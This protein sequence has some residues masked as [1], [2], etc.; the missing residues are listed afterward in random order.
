MKSIRKV[1]LNDIAR[2]LDMT[3]ATVSRALNGHTAI[4]EQT[5]K[6][7]QKTAKRLNYTP[8]N[9]AS[10]LRLG[11]SRIIG[12]IIPSAEINFFGSVV[13]G[14]EKIAN[15]HGYTVLLYQSNELLDFEQKG[16]QTFIRSRVDGVLA[17]LSKEA[18]NADHFREIRKRGIPLVLFD[19]VDDSLG[20]PS[21]V[22]NDYLGA[23]NA[24]QHLIDQGCKRIA[25]IG[26]QQH[27]QIFASRF[28]GYMDALKKNNRKIDEKLIMHGE[29]TIDSGR[30]CM[31]EVLTRAKPDGV[32]A[33]EDFTALG[34]MQALKNAGK[35]IP[36]D[37]A[38]IG[39][40]NETFGQYI[41]PSL[42]TI[43]QQTIRMGE[44]AA[45][46]FFNTSASGNFYEK[47][48]TKLVLEPVS[49]YRK[50]SLRAAV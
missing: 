1:T 10:S 48:P 19:R 42:S 34:C 7:V 30:D 14:I 27:V 20:V 47:P 46:M 40:A 37:V 15:E 36:D 29:V 9:I 26:G 32:F 2:E 18:T 23:Y 43:D 39:F 21:V 44:E 33:V 35:V 49:I 50:S 25:H 5:R 24:T 8:N 28:R 16:I 3:A 45:R 4:S 17:S 12:V 41:T 11:K 31:N 6:A 22:V 38:L 13:H